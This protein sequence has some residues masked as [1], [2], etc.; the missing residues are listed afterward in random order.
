MGGDN[1]PAVMVVVDPGMGVAQ[2]CRE[3]HTGDGALHRA[4][5][6]GDTGAS[7]DE[8]GEIFFDHLGQ[9]LLAGAMQMQVV[10]FGVARAGVSKVNK[11]RSSSSCSNATVSPAS[12]VA[13]RRRSVARSSSMDAGWAM[14]SASPRGD[15]L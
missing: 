5:E 15:V 6:P 7:L 1:A 9:D 12:W 2:S 14:R 13:W 8:H 4:Q 3:G 11:T 10:V